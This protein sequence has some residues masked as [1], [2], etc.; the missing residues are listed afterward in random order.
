MERQNV[1]LALPKE[2]IRKAKLIAVERRLSL[3]GLMTQLLTDAVG[4]R[5]VYEH[6]RRRSLARMCQGYNFG[7]HG[8]INWRREELHER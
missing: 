6:A 3:S 7:T 2:I 1:T 5:E 4:Q 8:V